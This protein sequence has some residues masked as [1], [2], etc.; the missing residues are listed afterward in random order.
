MV[1]QA[2]R[3]YYPTKNIIS[4]SIEGQQL[5]NFEKATE[6]FNNKTQSR[7]KQLL[8]TVL[9]GFGLPCLADT[10]NQACDFCNKI[11]EQDEA[12]TDTFSVGENMQDAGKPMLTLESSK[13]IFASFAPV[14]RFIRVQ[15]VGYGAIPDIS[16]NASCPWVQCACYKCQQHGSRS[17]R[18][19]IRFQ[20]GMCFMCGL[21]WVDVAGIE[22]KTKCIIHTVT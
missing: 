7:R 18:F 15:Y 14:H 20:N 11:G 17:C 21:P 9:N 1:I 12:L 6:C 10:A 4:K 16:D 3:L 8:D 22:S 5:T 2:K 13:A 19:A